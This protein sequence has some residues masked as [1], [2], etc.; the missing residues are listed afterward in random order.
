MNVSDA[1][2]YLKSRMVAQLQQP[3]LGALAPVTS[4]QLAREEQR[5]LS[6]ASGGREAAGG[7]GAPLS[8]ARE[9]GAGATMSVSGTSGGRSERDGASQYQHHRTERHRHANEADAADARQ[10][11][12]GMQRRPSRGTSSEAQQEADG[13]GRATGR[14]AKDGGAEEVRKSGPHYDRDRGKKIW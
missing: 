8:A 2:R 5:L 7:M 4:T 1:P 12:V 10:Q 11:G 3:Q 9:G 13:G 6:S 14:P